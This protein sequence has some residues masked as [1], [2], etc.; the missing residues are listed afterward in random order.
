MYLYIYMGAIRI[1]RKHLRIHR[2]HV[3]IY[4]GYTRI[5]RVLSADIYFANE[6]RRYQTIRYNI[7]VLMGMFY[8]IPQELKGLL[9]PKP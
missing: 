8:P 3:R 2:D 4:R 6:V 1:Y 9:N 7:F 5:Y